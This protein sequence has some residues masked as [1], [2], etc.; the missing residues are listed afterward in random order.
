M[1]N[2]NIVLRSDKKITL[3]YI[4]QKINRKM[5]FK[6]NDI[7]KLRLFNYEGKIF[8][9]ISLLHKFIC[10]NGLKSDLQGYNQIT[11]RIL[12]K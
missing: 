11:D 1:K 7:K 4:L 6:T 8:Y 3:S 10:Q 2:C 5:N 12:T 9:F